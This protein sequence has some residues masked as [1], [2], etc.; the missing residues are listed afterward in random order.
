[1]IAPGEGCS[2]PHA[3][4]VDVFRSWESPVNGG[5]RVKLRV[6]PDGI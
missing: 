4:V 1:M 5:N 6:R 2:V 3:V